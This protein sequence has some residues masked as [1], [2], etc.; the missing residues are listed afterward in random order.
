MAEVHAMLGIAVLSWAT[1]VALVVSVAAILRRPDAG[2]GAA[3][4]RR[5]RGPYAGLRSSR[6]SDGARRG[7]AHSR[8]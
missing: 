1:L 5:P 8:A 3:R 4:R 2:F 6:P 7:P